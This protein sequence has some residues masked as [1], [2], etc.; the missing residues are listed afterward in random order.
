MPPRFPDIR[1]YPGKQW[2]GVL[3]LAPTLRDAFWR[4]PEARI[5]DDFQAA[6]ALPAIKKKGVGKGPRYLGVG[7][8]PGGTRLDGRNA[9]RLHVP[10]N[11]PSVVNG[12]VT[13]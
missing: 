3:A 1:C 9:Y 8:G 4:D 13:D 7:A 6:M 11:P 2:E 5:D 10:P 12:C